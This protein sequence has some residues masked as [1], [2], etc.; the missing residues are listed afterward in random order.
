MFCGKSCAEEEDE[1]VAQV[2]SSTMLR[3]SGL[4]VLEL[5]LTSV[6]LPQQLLEVAWILW[7][8]RAM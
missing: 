5:L 4:S 6:G 2:S 1:S 3:L 7:G 8:M